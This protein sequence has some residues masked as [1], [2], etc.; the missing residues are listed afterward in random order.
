M[1]AVHQSVKYGIGDGRIAD[2]R[3]PVLDRELAGD[4]GR[5]TAVTI[6]NDFQKILPLLGGQWG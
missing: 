1:G 4:D 5:H 2:V 6:V 3:V